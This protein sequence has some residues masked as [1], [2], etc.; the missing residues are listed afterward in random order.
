MPNRIT[1]AELQRIRQWHLA[2]HREQPLEAQLWDGVLTLWLMGWMGWVPALM[3]E[4]IW[5]MPLCLL[6]MSLPGFYVR[7]RRQAHV[8]QR[9]RCD[10][11]PPGA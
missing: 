4:A 11:L 9:L 1:L 7:W 3:L 6:A 2:H 5:A 10:W 8:Q